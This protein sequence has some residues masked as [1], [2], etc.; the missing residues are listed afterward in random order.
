MDKLTWIRI[1]AFSLGSLAVL[2]LLMGM[3]IKHESKK[4]YGIL[5]ASDYF[6]P[7]NGFPIASDADERNLICKKLDEAFPFKNSSLHPDHKCFYGLPGSRYT[8]I[9][10]YEITD[11]TE[12]KKLL[13]IARS[14]RREEGT[15]SFAVEFYAKETGPSPRDQFIQKVR[16]D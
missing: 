4:W 8:L 13:Q 14:I 10:V 3:G 11:P 2:V 16:I 9:T 15:R 7:L 1:S 12:Q 6:P 5:Y